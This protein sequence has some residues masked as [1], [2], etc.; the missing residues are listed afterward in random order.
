MWRVLLRRRGRCTSRSPRGTATPTTSASASTAS[1]ALLS[2]SP[3]RRA[4][5][6]GHVVA[7]LR[8]VSGL[9]FF[10]ATPVFQIVV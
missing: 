2:A 1:G 6:E 4:C 7:W 5:V 8:I 9:R 3:E 10:V